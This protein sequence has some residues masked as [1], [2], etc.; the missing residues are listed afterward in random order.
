MRREREAS[1]GFR[2]FVIVVGILA[3]LV[4]LRLRPDHN[5][6]FAA[7][8]VFAAVVLIAALVEHQRRHR[9]GDK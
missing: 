6:I 5:R 2:A 3:I 8:V 1:A 4:F 9:D 7:F